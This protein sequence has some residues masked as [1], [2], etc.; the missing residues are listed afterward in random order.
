MAKGKHDQR[1]ID[2]A[3]LVMNG[4]TKAQALKEAG[5]D[6]DTEAAIRSKA[7]RLMNDPFV[8]DEIERLKAVVREKKTYGL[9]ECIAEVDAAYQLAAA[10]DKPAPMIQ[11]AQFKAK[12]M[13]LVVDKAQVDHTSSDGSMSPTIDASKLSDETINQILK[14]RKKNG[15]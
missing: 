6:Q 4:R 10:L 12:L 15:N 8:K 7:S 13:G 3:Y 2:F 11:A 1:K 9:E 5:F 14:A